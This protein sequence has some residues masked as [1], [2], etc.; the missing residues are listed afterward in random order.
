MKEQKYSRSIM[1]TSIASGLINLM[2]VIIPIIF[3]KW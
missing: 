3:S 2:N 1:V